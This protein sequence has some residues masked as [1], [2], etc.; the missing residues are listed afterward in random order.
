[1]IV[2][3]YIC[4]KYCNGRNI[5][6]CIYIFLIE[7]NRCVKILHAFKDVIITNFQQRYSL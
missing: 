6:N 3:E 5:E 7:F 1:M 4:N 2:K